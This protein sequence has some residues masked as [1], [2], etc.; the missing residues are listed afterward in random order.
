MEAEKL[1]ERKIKNPDFGVLSGSRMYGTDV[2]GSD[3]DV[4]GFIV[5]P[6]VYKMGLYN[7]GG[8]RYN[9]EVADRD[10]DGV[11]LH[12]SSFEKWLGSVLKG[13]VQPT[14]ILFAPEDNIQN[15]SEFGSKVLDNKEQLLSKNI[16]SSIRGYAKG[17]KRRAL[18]KTTGRLGGKRK[19]DL[20][21]FG[22]VRKNAYHMVR[23]LDQGEELLRTGQITFPRPNVDLLMDLREGELSRDEVENHFIIY[24][25]RIEDTMDDAVLPEDPDYE[26][27]NHLIRESYSFS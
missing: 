23:L 12:I 11:D 26:F 7:K 21:E 5:V 9:F 14:E 27:A 2:G 17:E 25:K 16:Y 18:G 15:L 1:L 3:F 4:R 22:Y 6:M 13:N 20:E 8:G 19:T 10:S 24:N